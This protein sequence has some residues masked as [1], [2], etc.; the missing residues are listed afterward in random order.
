MTS[1]DDI[2]ERAD[3][4]A[5]PALA[6]QAGEQAGVQ[7]QSPVHGNDADSTTR[8]KDARTGRESTLRRLG[9]AALD[10]AATAAG[11][12]IGTAVAGWVV[13]WITNR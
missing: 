11:K 5:R 7:P 4:P 10:G 1:H 12:V 2:K 9:R 6:G 3:A 8:G 13:W